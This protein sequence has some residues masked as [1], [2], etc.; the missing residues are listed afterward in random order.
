M[1]MIRKG[2][3]KG[4]NKGDVTGQKEKE[5]ATRLV[6]HTGEIPKSLTN[7]VCGVTAQDACGKGKG[8]GDAAKGSRLRSWR[9]IGCVLCSDC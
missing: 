3:M 9:L 1:H 2:Q 4:V 6:L 8:R 5:D 7:T